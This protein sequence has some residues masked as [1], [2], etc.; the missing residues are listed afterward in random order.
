MLHSL[1]IK[2]KTSRGSSLD[3]DKFDIGVGRLGGPSFLSKVGNE[4]YDG[5]EG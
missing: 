4:G 5:H 1:R 3:A 2:R